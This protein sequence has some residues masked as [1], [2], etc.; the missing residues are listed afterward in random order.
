MANERQKC[1]RLRKVLVVWFVVFCFERI[2]GECSD[3]KHLLRD[4]GHLSSGP[5]K[6]RGL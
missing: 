5:E 1:E 3:E 6:E 4:G 2:V